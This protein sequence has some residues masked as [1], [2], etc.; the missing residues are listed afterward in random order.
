MILYGRGYAYEARNIRCLLI[1]NV[2]TCLEIDSNVFFDR[3]RTEPLRAE[4]EVS[5]T[6]HAS[7]LK[8]N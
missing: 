4:A 6:G 5:F 2:L 7:I 3:L 1:R 8:E